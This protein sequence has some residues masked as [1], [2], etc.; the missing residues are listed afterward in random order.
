[1]Y[2]VRIES[3]LHT[4]AHTTFRIKARTFWYWFRYLQSKRASAD[5]KMYE[6]QFTVF[7]A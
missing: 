7:F 6:N 3:L 5:T 4:N 2:S 1:M